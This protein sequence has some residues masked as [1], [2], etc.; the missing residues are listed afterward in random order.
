MIKNKEEIKE[1]MVITN[2]GSNFTQKVTVT[3]VTETHVYA[4]NSV[5]ESVMPINFYLKKHNF[6][7]SNE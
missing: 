6:S 5:H 7:I 2:N 3:K 4:K 1:G